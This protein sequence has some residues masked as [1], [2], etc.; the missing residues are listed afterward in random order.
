MK[1]LALIIFSHVLAAAGPNRNA[2]LSVDLLP[3]TAISDSTRSLSKDSG[4]IWVAVRAAQTAGLDSYGFEVGFD[5]SLLTFVLSAASSPPDGLQ[6]FLESLGGTPLGYVGRLS[7]WDS[8]K[9]SIAHALNGSDSAQ[10]PSGSGILAL[11]RFQPR[12]IAGNA[13]F[14]L[15][16]VQILDWRLQLDTIVN[17][18]GAR[19]TL[20]T[21]VRIVHNDHSRHTTFPTASILFAFN[22]DLLG[23]SPYKGQH[24]FF[25][26]K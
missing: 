19:L 15:G 18:V 4:A 11:L 23:R 20:T 1:L 26:K 21:V 2:I 14:S 17:V 7:T 6:N 24:S 16:A 13:L 8:T 22:R 10:S 9:V 25:L 12:G 5:S 3:G